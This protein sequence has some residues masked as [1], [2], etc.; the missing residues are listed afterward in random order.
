MMGMY[1]VVITPDLSRLKENLH[2]AMPDEKDIL[3]MA[4]HDHITLVRNRFERQQ[5]FARHEYR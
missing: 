2:K 5:S 3:V 1:D 4:S